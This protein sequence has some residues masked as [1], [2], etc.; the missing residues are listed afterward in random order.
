MSFLRID[1]RTLALAAALAAIL[2]ALFVPRIRIDRNVLDAVAF[3][4]VTVSM[5]TR[6]MGTRSAPLSRLEASKA[7][8]L[9]LVEELPC[10]S[11]LGIGL[12]TERR[13][14]LLFEPVDVCTSFAPVEG[15]IKEL[16]WRMAWEGDSFVAKGLYNAYD[17]TESLEANLVFL[18]DG[19]ESPPLPPGADL[20]VFE[21]KPGS[22]KGLIVGVGS[23]EKSPIPKFDSDGR[24]AGT[25][26]AQDVVQEN[27]TGP[28]PKD[29]EKRPGYHPKWAPFGSGPPEGDEHLT[30]VRTTHLEALSGVT[31]LSYAE[32]KE[33]PSLA[34][35]LLS[36][37]KTRTVTVETDIRPFVA[38]LALALLVAVYAIPLVGSLLVMLQS[39]P[40]AVMKSQLSRILT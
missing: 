14:F 24:E 3:L 11:R 31:G 34:R 4:D 37:S 22:V 27:R 35:V 1:A 36:A 40:A 33:T 38:A 15:A 28:P 2:M 7:A 10:G 29:A 32:L 16:D 23:R 18:T 20:P 19:H 12:F 8:L 21:G 9:A 30:S 25:Y 26:G 6:D 5:M 39:P 13:S 17:M